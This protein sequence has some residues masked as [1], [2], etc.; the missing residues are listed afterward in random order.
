MTATLVQLNVSQGGVPKR[1]VDSARVTCGGVEGDV[2]RNLKYHGGPDRAVCIY[3]EEF[4]AELRSE[5]IDV[6][7]GAFGEN[8]T[9]SGVDLNLLERG[10]RLR[11]GDCLVEI[12]D[13]RV[14]CSTLKKWSAKL[15]KLIVGRSGW[16]AKV[17]EE[18]VVRPGDAIEVIRMS[19]ALFEA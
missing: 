9:T 1:P 17:I 5:G 15:P 19:P 11:V 7:N 13:V 2:Q 16:V 12:T 3:S 14:P 6:T 4:Y 10:D 18:A 8:F